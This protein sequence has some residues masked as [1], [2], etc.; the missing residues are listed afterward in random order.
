MVDGPARTAGAKGI[1]GLQRL[2]QEFAHA[3]ATASRRP[4]GL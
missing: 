1:W 2:F 4:P 3:L